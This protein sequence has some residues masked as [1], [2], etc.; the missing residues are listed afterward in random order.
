MI[1]SSPPWRQ[2]WRHMTASNSHVPTLYLTL[3][4]AESYAPDIPEMPP[5]RNPMHEWTKSPLGKLSLLGTTIAERVWRA[6]NSDDSDIHGGG[7]ISQSFQSFRFNTVIFLFGEGGRGGGRVDSVTCLLRK[8]PWTHSHHRV[9]RGI[10]LLWPI[11]SCT[12]WKDGRKH[13]KEV[14]TLYHQTWI[15]R[16]SML[17]SI[18]SHNHN[19][20][21]PYFSKPVNPY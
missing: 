5:N 20:L 1:P 15:K 12:K 19:R 4:P 2:L 9:W 8:C 3:S 18:K 7:H 16:G 13:Y 6:W 17:K 14:N 10:Q 21:E 11:I